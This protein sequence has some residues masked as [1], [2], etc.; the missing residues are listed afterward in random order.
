MEDALQRLNKAILSGSVIIP[1][2]LLTLYV[3]K[4]S[5]V[6]AAFHLGFLSSPF[7][8]LALSEVYFFCQS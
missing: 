6:V 8:F 3:I 1:N 7:L 5:P 4:M 2:S